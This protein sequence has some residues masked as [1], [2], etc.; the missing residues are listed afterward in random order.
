MCLCMAWRKHCMSIAPSIAW[1]IPPGCCGPLGLVCV[2]P[3]LLSHLG[4]LPLLPGVPALAVAMQRELVLQQMP[5]GPDVGINS[6]QALGL[7]GQTVALPRSPKQ[8]QVRAALAGAPSQRGRHEVGAPEW[9]PRRPAFGRCIRCI[10][11]THSK[12][13]APPS[14]RGYGQKRLQLHA[15]AVSLSIIP[16]FRGIARAPSRA[17]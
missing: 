10:R 9:H 17:R 14:R 3:A 2:A 15:G 8:D 11:Y 4:P 16:G 7:A 12:P 1:S 13:P 5:R 6:E